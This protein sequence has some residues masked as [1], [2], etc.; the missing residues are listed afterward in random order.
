MTMLFAALWATLPAPVLPA[1]C[2]QDST[3]PTRIQRQVSATL[4]QRAD[5]GTFSGVVLVACEGR[6]LFSAAHGFADRRRSTPNTLATRFNL[7][8]ANKMWTAVAIAQ[9][10]EQGRLHVDSPVGHYLPDFPNT[11]VR[12][13]VLVRHLLTHTSGLGSYFRRGYLRDR[14]ALT[15][16]S[17]LVRFFAEDS[18]AFNPGDRFLYS[19]AG[20]AVLGMIVERL[21]GLSYYDYVTRH[22]LE[23]AGMR[24]AGF[25]TLPLPDTGY[26][27]GYASP[28]GAPQ[29]VD[30]S[31][32]IERSSSPAGGG[33]ADASSM[34][35][36]G[37][38]LWGGRLAGEALVREFTTGKVDMMGLRYGF[39][40][41]E[42]FPGGWRMVGHNGGAPGVGVEFASFPE[43]G[44]DV[45]VL[46][47][48][49]MPEA[50]QVLATIVGAIT[51]TTPRLSVPPTA[52]RP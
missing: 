49:D 22:V 21:S 24:G 36:F 31:D 37:R 3:L 19:N 46:T 34:V 52:R 30:N 48:V 40:F 32:L 29:P 23:R 15:R 44:I 33:Y 39:G 2:T 43:Q 17:D 20:F 41:G 5:S 28:P 26:A 51:G 13:R 6:T 50:A 8:S 11:D 9:L 16:A 35:A 1:P 14:V 18:L 12:Q 7:G 38:A 27:T 42:S 47:N 25:L 45:V 10:V 4:R